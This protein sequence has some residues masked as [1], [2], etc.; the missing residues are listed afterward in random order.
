MKVRNPGIRW[1]RNQVKREIERE[2]ELYQEVEKLKRFYLE[3]TGEKKGE[4]LEVTLTAIAEEA[5]ERLFRL[6]E[7]VYPTESLSIIHDRLIEHTEPDAIRS[8]AIELLHNL[9][10]PEFSGTLEKVFDE[11]ALRET[12]EERIALIL[13]EMIESR[14]RWLWLAAH[15]LIAE[16]GLEERWPKLN[17]FASTRS[18]E[19]L[20]V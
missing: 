3:K 7:L 10:G 1:N 19:F 15:F 16:L 11:K 5:L 13:E 4:F 12:S 17:A 14:D 2:A 6:L 20:D 18:F 8:H 9:L